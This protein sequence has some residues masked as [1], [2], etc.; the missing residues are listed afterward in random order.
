M[1]E[2]NIYKNTTLFLSF[3]VLIRLIW[4]FPLNNEFIVGSD[5]SSHFFKVWYLSE[6]GVNDWNPLWYGGYSFLYY[7]PPISYLATHLLSKL[8][9]PIISFKIISNFAFLIAPLVFF[10]FLR[11]LGINKKLSIFASFIFSI[12]PIYP[13]YLLKGS[14]PTIF[15]FPLLILA[16]IF[17][18]KYLK[19]TSLRYMLLSVMFF[20]FALLSHTISFIIFTSMFLVFTIFNKKLS[21]AKLVKITFFSFVFST[22]WL[23]PMIFGISYSSSNFSLSLPSLP[24]LENFIVPEIYIYILFFAAATFF[25]VLVI[26]VLKIAYLRPFVFVTLIFFLFILFFSYK[27]PVFFLPIFGV[28][29][30]AHGI[31]TK[32]KIIKCFSIILITLIFLTSLFIRPSFFIAS[33]KEFYSKL[34]EGRSIC[35]PVAICSEKGL[36]TEELLLAMH[37]KQVIT[38]WFPQSQSQTK[39]KYFAML[40]NPLEKNQSTYYNLLREGFVNNIIVNKNYKEIVNYFN[41]SELFEKIFE[42][43]N[44]VVFSPKEKFSYVELNGKN[45]DGVIERKNDEILINTFCKEEGKILIKESFHPGW[46]IYLN[47]KYV[48]AKQSQHGFIE[49]PASKGKCEIKMVFEKYWFVL[50]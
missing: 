7:Y 1:L 8:T 30:L 16:S 21:F 29:I 26:N 39:L 11:E 25:M 49:I 36:Y 43:E 6:F 2:K 3:L 35:L 40:S 37:K 50:N 12:F 17:Y 15:T 18:I 33:E 20:S 31:I 5:F 44:F 23:F 34:V 48:E 13:Y 41:S 19:K 47:G 4:C 14:F 24:S 45:L 22:P 38:G 42:N 10:I 27:R 32:R 28:V 46:E 9:S